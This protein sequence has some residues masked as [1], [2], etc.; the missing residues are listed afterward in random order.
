MLRIAPSPTQKLPPVQLI[1]P[2]LFSTWF[3]WI[4]PPPFIVR[5]LPNGIVVV[6]APLRS[7]PVHDHTPPTLSA[8]D[9]STWRVPDEKAKLLI[10]EDCVGS[11]SSR[12]PPEIWKPLPC[13]LTPLTTLVPADRI[14]VCVYVL[15]TQ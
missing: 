14:T 2:A 7:P 12:L 6:P 1:V 3:A 11:V 13:K 8:T 15:G 10:A 5:V 9:V 4:P